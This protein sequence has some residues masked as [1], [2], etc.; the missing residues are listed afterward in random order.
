MRNFCIFIWHSEQFIRYSIA[1]GFA[2]WYLSLI[3]TNTNTFHTSRAN[4]S[5]PRK[6]GFFYGCSLAAAL[7]DT[8]LAVV[9][10][11]SFTCSRS[12]T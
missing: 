4:V 3:Y 6:A 11:I 8:L 10:A 1:S 7:S 5:P 2:E 9:S 12:F